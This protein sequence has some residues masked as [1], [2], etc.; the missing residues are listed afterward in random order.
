MIVFLLGLM[1][2]INAQEVRY[3]NK[4]YNSL[5]RL[6]IEHR[7]GDLNVH[8]SP[9][10]KTTVSAKISADGAPEDLKLFLDKIEIKEVK[11]GSGVKLI[12]LIETKRW[13]NNNGKIKI[14]FKDGTKVKDITDFK[15][16]YDVHVGS[17]DKLSLKNK[18]RNIY[19]A[20]MSCNTSIELHDGDLFAG[21]VKNDFNLHVK[22]GKIELG[23]VHN[24]DLYLYDSKL[25]MKNAEAIELE[26]KYSEIVIGDCSS[27]EIH[28][29]DDEFEVGQIDGELVIEDKYSEFEILSCGD[30][31][32]NFYDG[33][34]ELGIAQSIKLSTK[35]SEYKFKE[36]HSLE[37]DKSHDDDFNIKHLG[38]FDCD[39][40]KYTSYD[41][42]LLDNG[43]TISTYDDVI[44][45]DEIGQ[46]FSKLN[47]EGKYT[48]LS[49]PLDQIPGFELD[50]KRKYGKLIFDEANFSKT[51]HLEQDSEQTLK[52]KSGTGQAKVILDIYDCRVRFM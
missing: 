2:Q 19:L 32:V 44:D 29:Y 49:I 48:D 11:S 24:A 50:S 40:S 15:I 13:V 28:S 16:T 52:G 35:Y 42:D 47:M 37:I 27:L 10:G 41:I 36:V 5:D 8:Q 25:N 4:E 30:S 7:Y 46:T 31:D 34:M 26:S 38:R 12:T 6:E 43:F 20:D 3:V 23:N 33:K 9:S 18:Y 51:I 39:Q 17:V 1:H 14:T 22:Y 45:I 21:D